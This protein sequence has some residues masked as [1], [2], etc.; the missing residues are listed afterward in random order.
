MNKPL[1][2]EEILDIL[3]HSN[4]KGSHWYQHLFGKWQKQAK[5]ANGQSDPEAKSGSSESGGSQSEGTKKT[6][7]AKDIHAPGTA[8]NKSEAAERNAQIK[9]A[10][11]TLSTEELKQVTERI[12]AEKEFL[13]QALTKD[14]NPSRIERF[15]NQIPKLL[16]TGSVVLL[17]NK[18]TVANWAADKLLLKFSNA[19]EVLSSP[20]ASAQDLAAIKEMRGQFF[21]KAMGVLNTMEALSKASGNGGKKK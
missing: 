5:Y 15:K 3:E 18:D 19:A 2:E 11:E 8:A 17:A 7:A 13:E 6:L 21:S 12:K 9:E 16:K 10:S 4:K 20:N 14:Y 1:S